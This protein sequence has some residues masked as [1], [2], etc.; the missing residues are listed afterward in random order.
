MESIGE[1]DGKAYFEEFTSSEIDAPCEQREQSMCL[2][3]LRLLKERF[4]IGWEFQCA[5]GQEHRYLDILF[6]PE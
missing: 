3:L 6:H 5:K 2:G 1:E 4:G